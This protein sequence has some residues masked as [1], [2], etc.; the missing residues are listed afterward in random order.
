MKNGTQV[1]LNPSSVIGDL[2]FSKI[3]QENWKLN[4]NPV[5]ML[6]T[7]SRIGN[8]KMKSLPVLVMWENGLTNSYE[9]K[10]LIEQI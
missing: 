2:I 3:E 7:V 1:K 10:N 6:G 9:Y 4:D 5:N 8:P